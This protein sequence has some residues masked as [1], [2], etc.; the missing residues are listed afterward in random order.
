MR[1]NSQSVFS[2]VDKASLF[3]V[4]FESVYS[5][6]D[7]NQ[8]PADSTPRYSWYYWFR[9]LH[10]QWNWTLYVVIHHLFTMS[11]WYC[12]I[13]FGLLNGKSNASCLFIN[14]VTKLSHKLQ[15]HLTAMLYLKS[16]G[17]LNV[18]QDFS[19][20]GEH[21]LNSSI[22]IFPVSNNCLHF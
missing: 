15:T 5:K 16:S 1:L 8:S 17:A 12:K 6:S 7:D 14:Q 2:D 18:W 22:W 11:L 13:P 19:I 21:D 9:C 10:F 20:C 4:F 3:N